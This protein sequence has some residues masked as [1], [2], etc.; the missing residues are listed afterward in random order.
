MELKKIQNEKSTVVRLGL[1]LVAEWTKRRPPAQA[2]VTSDNRQGQSREWQPRLVP[3]ASLF[4]FTNAKK[5]KGL[6]DWE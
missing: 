2:Q 3:L 5:Q 1:L 6:P 4:P